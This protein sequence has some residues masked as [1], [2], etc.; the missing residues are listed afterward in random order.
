MITLQEKYA[1]L[2]DA[3]EDCTGLWDAA[4]EIRSQCHDEHSSAY[5]VMVEDAKAVLRELLST[6]L[7]QLFQGHVEANGADGEVVVTNIDEIEAALNN[8]DYWHSSRITSDYF[9][10]YI[11]DKGKEVWLEGEKALEAILAGRQF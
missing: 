6:E 4:W 5:D 7:V 8:S 3:A 1:I 11:T 9:C 10:F 2:T